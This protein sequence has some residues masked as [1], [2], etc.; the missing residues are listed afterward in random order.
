M[1]PTRSPCLLVWTILGGFIWSNIKTRESFLWRKEVCLCFYLHLW[2]VTYLTY[3]SEPQL[4]QKTWFKTLVGLLSSQLYW[5]RVAL[6]SKSSGWQN[7]FSMDGKLWICV[8]RGHRTNSNERIV[9]RL[10]K[11]PLFWN[12]FLLFVNEHELLVK[13][14]Y[15]SM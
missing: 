14:S 3:W 5:A 7:P 6:A 8:K 2:H 13:P 15:L 10:Y 12:T 9:P 4:S 1:I 11:W